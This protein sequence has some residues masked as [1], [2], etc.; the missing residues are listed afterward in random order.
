[1]L[2]NF[3]KLFLVFNLIAFEL[4]VGISL[5]YEK[6]ACDPPSTC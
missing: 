2:Y 3:E 1:M 6:N 5:N 4:V